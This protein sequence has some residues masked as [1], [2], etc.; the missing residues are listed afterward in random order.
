[1]QV[2]CKWGFLWASDVI[3][4]GLLPWRMLK[5]SRESGNLH[6]SRGT[7]EQPG[8]KWPFRE[9]YCP[10]GGGLV[11]QSCPSDFSVTPC[12]ITCQTSV[13]GISQARILEWDAMP[14]SRGSSW[15][16]DWTWSPALTG[17]FFTANLQGSPCCPSVQFSSS[18]VSDSLQP[19]GLQHV[20]LPCPSPTP[21]ACLN[22]CPS[23]L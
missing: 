2:D 22:A 3:G 17:G 14:S 15:P 13:H 10:C 16:R 18:V 21:R 9:P 20:R 4:A 1:M 19:Y 8:S 12:T 11:A 5:R 7:L 23:S 6:G